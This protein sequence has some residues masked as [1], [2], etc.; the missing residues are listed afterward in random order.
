[1]ATPFLDK[2]V[3]F[4]LLQKMQLTYQASQMLGNSVSGNI[5]SLPTA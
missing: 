1:M 5:N 2:S 3:A 4:L